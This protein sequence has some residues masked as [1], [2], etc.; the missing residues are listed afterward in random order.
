MPAVSL[1]L[2]PFITS[3]SYSDCMSAYF[4]DITITTTTTSITATTTA[5]NNNERV[6]YKNLSMGKVQNNFSR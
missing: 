6:L 5:N 1:V 4:A 3:G 2:M